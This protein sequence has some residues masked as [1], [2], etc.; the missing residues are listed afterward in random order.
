M[1][2]ITLQLERWYLQSLRDLPFRKTR[3]AYPVW[4]SEIMAQQTRIETMLPYYA[5]WM[6]K[7]PTIKDLAHAEQ[8][9]VLKMWEGLGYYTR[10]RNLH[11]GAKAIQA[12]LQGVFPSS[13]DEI[14]TLPGIGPYTAADIASIVFDVRVP[15]I[16]G[17]V[18]RVVSRLLKIEDEI[19]SAQAMQIVKS[20]MSDWMETATP[21]IFTQAMMELGALVCTPKSPACENCPLQ[22][23]CQAYQDHMQASYPHKKSKAKIPVET[24][25]CY[26]LYDRDGKIALIDQSD[27][28]LMNGYYRFPVSS[29]TSGMEIRDPQPLGSQKHVYSHKIW[30][31]E[32]YEAHVAEDIAGF[33]WVS[34]RELDN[35][36]LIGAHRKFYQKQKA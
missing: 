10:A 1:E 9:E 36:P 20:A 26:L 27:D 22:G 21:H 31:T 32:Y 4:V 35:L 25:V 15:A 2:N 7:W 34:P 33:H 14:R 13:Y 17:N 11:A 8:R 23:L 30:V 5:R 19:S 3:E 16:D 28:G 12:D 29:Q 18:L 24:Y 6:E